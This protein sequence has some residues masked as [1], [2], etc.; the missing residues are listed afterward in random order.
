[1]VSPKGAISILY[2]DED[3]LKII[4]ENLSI[5]YKDLELYKSNTVKLDP[6]LIDVELYRETNLDLWDFTNEECKLHYINYGYYEKRVAYRE[7][8]EKFLYS[9]YPVISYGGCY[10]ITPSLMEKIKVLTPDI[11]NKIVPLLLPEV[12]RVSDTNITTY[13]HAIER[14][15]STLNSYYKLSIVEVSSTGDVLFIK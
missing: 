9:N 5:D 3:K 8:Y 4:L 7:V 11:K 1:M 13:T 10:M 15:V 6:N 14:F 2:N 12:K